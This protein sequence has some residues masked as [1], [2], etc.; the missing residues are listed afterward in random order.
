MS[1]VEWVPKRFGKNVLDASILMV[2]AFQLKSSGQSSIYP[3][4]EYSQ[5]RWE[6]PWLPRQ[7]LFIDWAPD[8][9]SRQSDL[10]M[11]SVQPQD[12]QST[13]SLLWEPLASISFQ[14]G[15]SG[16][17]AASWDQGLIPPRMVAHLE[18]VFVD[19]LPMEGIWELVTSKPLTT[20]LLPFPQQNVKRLRCERLSCTLRSLACQPCCV[21]YRTVREHR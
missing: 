14:L 4:N 5:A 7:G 17:R 15:Q 3:K 19:H 11:C 13:G 16:A 21:L 6:G 9:S 12:M 20:S 8:K 18:A 2:L 10:A 1:Q